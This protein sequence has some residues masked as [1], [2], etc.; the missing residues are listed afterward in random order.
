MEL[1]KATRLNELTKEINECIREGARRFLLIGKL[2]SQV[3][4]DGLWQHSDATTFLEWCEREVKLKRAQSYNAMD[5]FERFQ[6]YISTDSAL[7]CIEQ[8]RLCRLLPFARKVED[9]EDKITEMLHMA[10]TVDTKGFENNLREMQNKRA[11][12]SCECPEEFQDEYTKCQLCNK[13]HRII[14]VTPEAP[15]D[16]Q[17]RYTV[18]EGA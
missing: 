5:C 8:T 14:D 7:D 9:D 1:V 13:F 3:K 11:D 12:D 16:A 2:L 18:R 4:N 15:L 17:V 6:N 10:A